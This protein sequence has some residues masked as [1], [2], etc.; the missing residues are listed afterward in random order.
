MSLFELAVE[1]HA[2]FGVDITR[3]DEKIAGALN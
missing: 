3:E 1:I 2:W